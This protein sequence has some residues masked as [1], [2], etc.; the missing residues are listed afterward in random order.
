MRFSSRRPEIDD[1]LAGAA[2]SSPTTIMRCIA[3]I[4]LRRLHTLGTLA[5]ALNKRDGTRL[6]ATNVRNHFHSTRPRD[7]TIEAYAFVLGLE[8]DAL[9]ALSGECNLNGSAVA[10]QVSA[11]RKGLLLAV[12]DF[13]AQAIDDALALLESADPDT[14]ALVA[15]QYFRSTN[16]SGT[17]DSE[18]IV[19]A[20]RGLID[21]RTRK[22]VPNESFLYDLWLQARSGLDMDGA[23]GIVA[24]AVGLLRR[25]GI[26]TAHYEERLVLERAA[27][28]MLLEESKVASRSTKVTQGKSE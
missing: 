3:E 25:R 28:D 18:A 15:T 20:F 5:E 10:S 9:W 6:E 14:R 4:A 12:G 23:E 2:K 1:G 24:L 16:E 17:S 13:E 11:L 19:A 8:A 7:S 26:D 22:R 21:L 27:S